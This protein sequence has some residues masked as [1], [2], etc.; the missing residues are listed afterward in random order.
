M[1]KEENRKL[2]PR[3]A[4]LDSADM[5]IAENYW[6]QRIQEECFKEE[7]L[8]L[9]KNE[10]VNRN[11]KLVKLSPYYDE[12]DGLIK[13]GGRVQY[14]DLREEEKHPIILPYSSYLVKLIIEDVHRKQLHSGINHTLIALRDRYWVIKARSLVR[15]VVKSCVV[16]RKYSP[17]RLRVQM[18]PLPRDRITQAYPFQVCGVDFTGPLFVSAG[19]KVKKSWIALYTCAT[20]RAVHLELV[21]DQTTESFLRSFRR[22]ISRRGMVSNFYSDNSLTLK[23]ADK[24][25][26]KCMELMQGKAFREYLSDNKITWKFIVDYAAWWGGFYERIMKSIKAPLKKVLGRSVFS[27]DE[28]YT[29]LTEV[30]AMV[31]SRPLTEVSDEPEDTKYLTPASFL[32]GRQLINIP[33][34]P[35][36]SSDKSLRKKELQKLCML[37]NKTL[38]RLWKTWREEYVRNLG[39]VPTQVKDDQCIRVGELVNVAEHSIPRAKWKVGRVVKC[40]AGPDGRVRTVWVRT[41]T[42]TYSR[43]IQHI[44]RLEAESLEDFN[45]LNI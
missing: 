39:T 13:M 41:G 33:V 10:A 8:K 16:C 7:L 20:V 28:L 15:R 24:E 17:I 45:K 40:K 26:K 14:S 11:S 38:Q 27:S 18:A 43:P 6:L 36:V 21:E 4:P 19:T 37:Q 22:M 29:L 23:C 30:E 31:N 44:S 25:L 35:V 2:G 3:C 32:I 34:K 42:G 1:H 12:K 9:Q 5:I